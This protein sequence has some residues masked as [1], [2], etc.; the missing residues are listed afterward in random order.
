M[1]CNDCNDMCRQG[2][3]CPNRV[4]YD[5][6]FI[7]KWIIGVIT[8]GLF[9]FVLAIGM[10]ISIIYYIPVTVGGW[11]YDFVMIVYNK[12]NNSNNT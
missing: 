12:W 2:R 8:I 9:P 7:P 3:D 5:V 4:T 1:S 10:I 6:S 11:V